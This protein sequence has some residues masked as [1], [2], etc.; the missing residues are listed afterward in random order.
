[1][2]WL[3]ILAEIPDDI[4]NKIHQ[5]PDP[6]NTDAAQE[7]IINYLLYGVGLVA[8]VMIIVAGIQMTTSAGDAGAVA[9]AKKTLTFAIIGLVVALL[10]YAIVN[11]VIG[12]VA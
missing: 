10:A 7:N 4:K 11:F 2:K 8:V 5:L 12:K 3:T 9:K 6:G 1:M